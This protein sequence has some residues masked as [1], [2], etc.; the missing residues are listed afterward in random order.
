MTKLV[1][2]TKINDGDM[3][4]NK[5][6][7]SPMKK[8]RQVHND[9][10]DYGNNVPLEIMMMRTIKMPMILKIL[11]SFMVYGNNSRRQHFCK[12]PA[13]IN[14]VLVSYSFFKFKLSF[15]GYHPTFQHI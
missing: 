4:Q 5:G 3:H 9:F 7:D 10:D 6:F 8:K 13:K 15:F 12:L 11:Q 2:K 1:F 14:D